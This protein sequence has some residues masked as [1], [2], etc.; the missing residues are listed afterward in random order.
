MASIT[1]EPH[2]IP[3]VVILGA[4]RS[5]RMGRPKLLLPWGRTSVLGHLL[6][7]W[8]GLGATQVAVVHNPR[9]A[10]MRAELARLGVAEE[11]TI[12]N[13]DPERGMFSSIQCASGWAGWAPGLTHWAIALGDQP[14]LRLETLR[15]LMTFASGRE[16][17]I[18]QP[19]FQGR[20]CHPVVLPRSLFSELKASTATDL[21]AF[22]AGRSVALCELDDPGLT[23]DL[24]RP[25]DYEKAPRP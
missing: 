18:C 24:D 8:R 14:H 4:G 1:V 12:P 5:R 15:G 2:F 17:Q 7:Q 25:E 10:V 13:P 20:R 16:H 9:D 22:L 23:L 11:A 6:W 21:R 19:A 3:G